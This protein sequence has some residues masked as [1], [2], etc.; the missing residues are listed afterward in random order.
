MLDRLRNAG[1]AQKRWTANGRVDPGR[2]IAGRTAAGPG[3]REQATGLEQRYLQAL[4]AGEAPGAE[5]SREPALGLRVCRCGNEIVRD[6]YG[7]DGTTG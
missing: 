7:I 2:S 4:D 1:E 5:G 6:S 3:V